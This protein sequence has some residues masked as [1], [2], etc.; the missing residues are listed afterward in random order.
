MTAT[1]TVNDPTLASFTPTAGFVVPLHS[2]EDVTINISPAKAE[3]TCDLEH[4]FTDPTDAKISIP[5]NI[6][7]DS[8]GTGTITLV[9]Q[10]GGDFKGQL[11]LHLK[12]DAP[13]GRKL[14]LGPIPSKSE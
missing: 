9:W 2:Q 12:S 11:W 13:G 4:E 14:K 5:P 10:S 6:V 3:Y 7:T 8:A 1:V